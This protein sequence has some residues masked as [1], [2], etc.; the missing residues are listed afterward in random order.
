MKIF[1]LFFVLLSLPALAQPSA[2]ITGGNSPVC[3]ATPS[4]ITFTGSNGTAPYTFT[5][6]VDG[7]AP[8]TITTMSGNS[9]NL[10]LFNYAPGN[11]NYTLISVQDVTSASSTVN[12]SVIQT[13]NPIPVISAGSD[14][15]VC[16]GTPVTLNGSGGITYSWSGGQTNGVSFLPTIG[17]Q[18]L[19]VTGT[20]VFGCIGQDQMILTV[21]PL[22]IDPGATIDSAYCNN[23]AITIN[24]GAQTA[25]YT[26]MWSN[27]STTA[28][29]NGL[30]AGPYIC[31]MYD[32]YGCTNQFTYVVPNTLMPTNCAQINGS[33]Y[34]DNDQNCTINSGD[35]P[36]ANRMIMATPG[37]YLAVTD[38]NGDYSFQLPVGT[39]SVFEV[40]NT[41]SYGNYCNV[42]YSVTLAN[43]TDISANNDFMDTINGVVDLAANIYNANVVPGFSFI[44]QPYYSSINVTGSLLNSAAWF[45]IPSGVTMQTWSYPHTI[46]N[47]TVY[48][49]INTPQAF[50]SSIPFVASTSLILGSTATFCAGVAQHPMELVTNNNTAC[51]SVIVIGSFDPN[52]KTM[53]LNGVQSD[54]TIL[55]TDQTLDYVIRF[56]NT[57]TAP[58]HDI[59][60]LDTIQSS[61]DLSSFEFIAASHNCSVSILDGNVLKFNF[62]NIML[63]DSTNNE[64][65]SHGFVHYRIRQNNQN[66]VGT[67]LNNTAYIYF[68]FNEAVVTNTTH[69]SIIIDDLGIEDEQL[70]AVSIYPNPSEAVVTIESDILIETI[71]ITDLNGQFINGYFSNS[72]STSLD[73]SY[74][75]SGVY[76]IQMNA[77]GGTV[78]KRI[79]IQ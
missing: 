8:Q 61:L 36:V 71:E 15:T 63:P 68:D 6:S 53:F 37:N 28:N 52:D 76:F 23:G 1:H 69:D 50:T 30:S 38:Q 20:S 44:V 26:F 24:Q 14:L 4:F 19:T 46:S 74:L 58:A 10:D 5:Y 48:F 70:F 49:T 25:G 39:Y 59:Y 75:T 56:Q 77:K 2:T 73:L 42:N 45:T 32:P 60:I 12:Q 55:L 79:I 35:F 27:G 43:P 7:G 17:T 57:G 65:E 78:L 67:V 29:L 22:P 66:T 16:L 72:H 34:F 62:P 41:A 31:Y 9:I 3:Q 33:V 40:F 47:D 18:I 11:F 54:S 64:P 21:V 13:V 51:H